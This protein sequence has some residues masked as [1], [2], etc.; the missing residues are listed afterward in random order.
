MNEE[1]ISPNTQA[2]DSD[3]F[4][5]DWME[6]VSKVL[7]KWK[8]ILAM[9]FGFGAIGIIAALTM[10]RHYQ[11]TMTLA[12][13]L[14]RSSSSISSITSLLG[15]G[16]V[17]LS[18]NTDAMSITLFP[19]ICNSTPFLTSLL[20][21]PV[22]PFV[23]REREVKE[24]IVAT[25][26][27]VF[28]HILRRDRVRTERQRR[29]MEKADAEYLYDDS[30]LDES[31]LTP[32][33]SFCVKALAG[34]ISADV[35]KKTGV[36]T[37]RVIMDDPLI[38]VQLADTVLS[39]LQSYVANYRTK[40]A[41]DDYNYYVML[42]D[43]SYKEVVRTQAAYAASVDY[44]RSVILQSVN[45]EKQR[46]Q[47]EANLANQVYSQIVQQRELAKAKIQEDKPVYAVVQPAVLPQR[48]M[49]SRVKTVLIWGV[50]GGFLACAW[51]AFGEDF[52]KKYRNKAT[53]R[54]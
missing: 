5:I 10:T 33:Q 47:N 21:V 43:E 24:G 18:D 13:E 25:S 36:T 17:S 32:R 34:A 3:D 46:L 26:T 27:T 1:Y 41:I 28:D 45:S 50:M 2:Q 37:V 14:R 53:T 40:K 51:A 9:G 42:A 30:V 22:T 52:W 15:M 4:E 49:E 7:K 20:N 54:A 31:R 16:N 39:R 6:I 19:E 8:L 38:A 35:D 12:P 11:V 48:S 23:P 44:D 29:N